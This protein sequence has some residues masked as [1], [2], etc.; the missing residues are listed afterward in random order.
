MIIHSIIGSIKHKSSDFDENIS[1]ELII[2]LFFII[3]I[4]YIYEKNIYLLE[5][6][7]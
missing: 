2:L 5:L 1:K 4:F 7:Y 6:K 3:S